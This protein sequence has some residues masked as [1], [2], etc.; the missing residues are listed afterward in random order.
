MR[1]WLSEKSTVTTSH[2]S[3]AQILVEKNDACGAPFVI[4]QWAAKPSLGVS[5]DL[6]T[7]R[8]ARRL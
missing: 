6:V 7:R 2:L 3:G 1:R 4:M 5:Y 8:A